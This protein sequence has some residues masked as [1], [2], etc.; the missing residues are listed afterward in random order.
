MNDAV[1]EDEVHKYANC[2]YRQS[3]VLMRKW[4]P[5]DAPANEKWRTSHKIVLPQ[6]FREEILT[7]AHAPPMAGHLGVNKV[8]H[9]ILT[10]FYWL[11]LK[12][13]VARFCRTCHNCQVVG[14]PNQMIPVAPLNQLVVSHLMT[15]SLTVWGHFPKL[16]SGIS[17]YLQ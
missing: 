6:K 3:G 9:K 5:P 12:H 10:H 16:N 7:L 1:G 8:Y 4:R 15:Y 11:K 14:K 13:D 2:F 17:F